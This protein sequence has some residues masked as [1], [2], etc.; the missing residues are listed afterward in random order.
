MNKTRNQNS[1][2]FLATLGVYLGLFIAGGAAPQVFA[3]SATTRGFEI[4]DEI[5][6]KD[7][8]DKNPKSKEDIHDEAIEEYFDNLREFVRNLQALH[9]IEKLDSTSDI[10]DVESI[11]FLPCPE[12]GGLISHHTDSHV[13]RW[14]LPA[15]IEAKFIAERMAG[16]GDCLPFT[17][18]EDRS[19]ARSA[20][21]RIKLDKSE[22]LY[23]LSINLSSQERTSPFFDG[24]SG[25]LKRT[26]FAK[27]K[28]LELNKALFKNTSS[29]RSESQV[30]IVTR[31]PRAGLDTLLAKNA[32]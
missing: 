23:E 28:D 17:E 12:T 5:E 2:L 19:E 18:I 3:H 13:D 16:Y 11:S 10:F 1:I 24:V 26:V 25:S 29:R 14:I 15:I 27:N 4:S 21:I 8:L 20:G 6:V 30:F 9:S 31:L 32:K 7:D 22:F